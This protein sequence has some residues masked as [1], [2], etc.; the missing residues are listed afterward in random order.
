MK[1][2]LVFKFA[3]LLALLVTFGTARA[4]ADAIYEVIGTMTVPGNSA[5]PGVGETVDYSFE[6]D[7]SYS[8]ING[9]YPTIIGTPEA[10]SFGPLGPY[11]VGTVSSQNYVF[12]GGGPE[13]DLLMDFFPT[14]GTPTV[15][16]PWLFGCSTAFAQM[17][18]AACA[19]FVEYIP[20]TNILGD[21]YG[22][23][24]ASV[25]LVST[26]EP[27]T[28]VLCVVGLFALCLKKSF[29]AALRLS[30]QD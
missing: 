15:I 30:R 28:M 27:A 21:V 2:K 4:R 6:L 13:L 7:Y 5:N 11:A 22:T 20:G 24:S 29:F 19:P 25:Y 8:G 1:L 16:E 3:S 10:I 23:A 9:G 18:P 26:P 12:F 14:S 17:N